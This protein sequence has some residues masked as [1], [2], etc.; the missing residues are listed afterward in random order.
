M[1]RDTLTVAIETTV[2]HAALRSTHNLPNMPG[3]PSRKRALCVFVSTSLRKLILG[4]HKGG[5][6]ETTSLSEVRAGDS[7][8]LMN[9]FE[10]LKETIIE[11]GGS[12]T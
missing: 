10:K 3:T 11:P 8:G 9:S 12:L 1:F 5:K 2:E 4:V 6:S 7:Y